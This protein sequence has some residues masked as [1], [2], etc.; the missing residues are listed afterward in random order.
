[1]LGSNFFSDPGRAA[2]PCNGRPVRLC[3]PGCLKPVPCWLCLSAGQIISGPHSD[4]EFG[5]SR[6]NLD[7]NLTSSTHQI[8]D[9]NT[10]NP[11]APFRIIAQ[12]ATRTSSQWTELPSPESNWA[13]T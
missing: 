11:A 4:L 9:C 12:S 3:A 7:S 10:S 2:G 6:I 1:M 13:Q 5:K 8:T